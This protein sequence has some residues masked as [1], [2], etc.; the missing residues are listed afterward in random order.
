MCKNILVSYSFLKSYKSKKLCVTSNMQKILYIDVVE[1]MLNIALQNY[2]SG[3]LVF[4]NK[5][6]MKLSKCGNSLVWFSPL[7][8][9]VY[10]PIFWNK[11]NVFHTNLCLKCRNCMFKRHTSI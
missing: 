8:I 2:M 3:S 7:E 9:F 5:I 10:P 11:K 6:G 1:A 4:S